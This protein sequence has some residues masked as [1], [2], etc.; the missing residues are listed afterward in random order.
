MKTTLDLPDELM[1]AVKIRAAERNLRLKDIVADALHAALAAPATAPAEPLDPVQALVR[2]L[3]FR[4]DG[5]VENPDASDDP[6]W[7]DTL[8]ALRAE[9]RRE[10]L[11]DPFGQRR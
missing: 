7:F 3:V 11:R 1:R 8:D 9:S 4:P 6:A 10:P 2:R 5:T